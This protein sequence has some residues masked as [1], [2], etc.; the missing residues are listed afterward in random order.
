MSQEPSARGC[1]LVHPF[2]SAR[3][4]CAR[5]ELDLLQ[6]WLSTLLC[7]VSPLTAETAEIAAKLQTA[8]SVESESVVGFSSG[9][10]GRTDAARRAAAAACLTASVSGRRYHCRVDACGLP[11]QYEQR[12]CGDGGVTRLWPLPSWRGLSRTT[13]HGRE[14]G[15]LLIRDAGDAA[16]TNWWGSGMPLRRWRCV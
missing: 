8:E 16:S 12:Q 11:G 9:R 14:V 10:G 15:S 5:G 6:S 1:Y 13:I 4:L 7:A 2:R 3:D